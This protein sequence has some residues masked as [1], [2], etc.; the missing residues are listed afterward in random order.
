[1]CTRGKQMIM[2]DHASQLTTGQSISWP[3]VS[4]TQTWQL[5]DSHTRSESRDFDGDSSASYH[6]GIGAFVSKLCAVVITIMIII[7]VIITIWVC[8]MIIIVITIIMISL[9]L[10]LARLHSVGGQTSNGRWCLSSSS[11]T[12]SAGRP[13]GRRAHRRSGSQH[14]MAGQYGY[15]PSNSGLLLSCMIMWMQSRKCYSSSEFF[16]LLAVNSLSPRLSQGE[17]SCQIS[18]SMNFVWKLSYEHMHMTDWS[19]YML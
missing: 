2:L 18:N 6:G 13:A 19:H 12:L 1:M 7:I 14:S 15:V 10:L 3:L 8:Q 16:L 4:T 17:S 5:A 11:V 9:L